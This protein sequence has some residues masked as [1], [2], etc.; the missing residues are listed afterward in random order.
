LLEHLAERQLLLVLGGFE[1]L[2]ETCAGPVGC[3]DPGCVCGLGRRRISSGPT[4][5]AGC[6]ADTHTFHPVTRR[7]PPTPP[8]PVRTIASR[9]SAA[10]GR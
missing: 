5:L 4:L 2:M 8:A 6:L 3:S 1:H 9:N 7:A 10:R